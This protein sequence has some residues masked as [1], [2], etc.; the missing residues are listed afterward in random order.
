MIV[1]DP[2]SIEPGDM[3]TSGPGKRIRLAQNALNRNISEVVKQLPIADVTGQ[4]LVDLQL[5]MNLGMM[6]LGFN[7][8]LMGQTEKVS[9]TTATESRQSAEAGVS[10]LAAIARIISCES[11]ADTAMQMV[12]NIQQHMS[13]EFWITVLGQ[14][15]QM[16]PLRVTADQLVGEYQYV[17]HD[18]TLPLDRV[19]L[20]N[21]WKELMTA[22][23][24]DQELRMKYD[25]GKVF[26]YSAEL[27]GAKNI[28]QMRRGPEGTSSPMPMPG[29]MAQAGLMEDGKVEE[30]ARKGNLVPIG[31]VGRG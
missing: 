16:V 20:L 31:G 22:V 15:G 17:I 4:N 21:V 10:R 2:M 25:A 3:D 1:Y 29:G 8:N 13:D 19:A 5:V 24:S 11:G 12:M 26:E 18:G 28:E 9:H 14:D 30:E 6:L 27:A 23:L 7:Q